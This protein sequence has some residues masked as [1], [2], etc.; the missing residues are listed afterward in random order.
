VVRGFPSQVWLPESFLKDALSFW[1]HLMA[2]NWWQLLVLDGNYS[3]ELW[4]SM[5]LTLDSHD[6]FL[7]IRTFGLKVRIPCQISRENYPV[8][9]W[10]I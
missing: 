8:E 5:K 9:F 6:N 10:V 3:H 2:Y 1:W 7:S 4:T